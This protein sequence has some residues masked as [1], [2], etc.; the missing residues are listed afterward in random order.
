MLLNLLLAIFYSNYQERVDAAL[1]KFMEHRNS[2]L[3][4]LFRQYEDADK[5]GSIGKEGVYQITKEIHSLV[6]G[7]DSKQ[8]DFDMTPLQFE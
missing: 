4:R 8:E 1:D 2:Y 7:H 5:P 6:N 3:V